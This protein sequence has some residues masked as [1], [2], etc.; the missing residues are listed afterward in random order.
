M[1]AFLMIRTGLMQENSQILRDLSLLQAQM[2]DLDGYEV[3]TIFIL[4]SPLLI[5]LVYLIFIILLFYSS[6]N[7]FRKLGIKF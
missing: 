6:S 5:Y 2:R 3:N 1:M 7:F 4:S